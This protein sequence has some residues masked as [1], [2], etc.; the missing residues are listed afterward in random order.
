M[1]LAYLSFLLATKFTEN[2]SDRF[3][4]GISHSSQSVAGE[5]A[6]REPWHVTDDESYA[7]SADS[8]NPAPPRHVSLNLW[9]Q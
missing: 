8:P 4:F 2:S 7:C 5:C 9:A 3:A 1:R 6:K